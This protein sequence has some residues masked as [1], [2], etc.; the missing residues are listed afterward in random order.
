M[1]SLSAPA[2]RL[3]L[4]DSLAEQG[5]GVPGRYR[6][7]A[8]LSGV[9]DLEDEGVLVAVGIDRVQVDAVAAG[10]QARLVGEGAAVTEVV[11]DDVP[12]QV[13]GEVCGHVAVRE[14]ARV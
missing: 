6:A 8:L 1:V 12:G 11:L 2:T 3:W 13:D 4:V 10:T 5:I 7:A 14:L 9:S